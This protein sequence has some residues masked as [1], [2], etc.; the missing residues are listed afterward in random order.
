MVHFI[1][2]SI[3]RH[4]S[5]SAHA[6]PTCIVGCPMGNLKY[7]QMYGYKLD[8]FFSLTY[9]IVEPRG[10]GSTPIQGISSDQRR[11]PNGMHYQFGFF[12]HNVSFV[13]FTFPLNF[14]W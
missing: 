7:L 8:R 2:P 14:T 9:L 13:K 4:D 3:F 6:A 11:M 1:R 10:F 12:L 5:L